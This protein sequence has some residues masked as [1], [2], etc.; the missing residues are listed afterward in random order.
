MYLS[1]RMKPM[2]MHINLYTMHGLEGRRH[3][4]EDD[5]VVAYAG[6]GCRS[7]C[8][9]ATSRAKI[10]PAG[11]AYPEQGERFELLSTDYLPLLEQDLY[12]QEWTE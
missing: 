4:Q 1:M 3:R 9:E 11:K 8:E 7:C 10:V 2:T 5:I 6:G 12:S